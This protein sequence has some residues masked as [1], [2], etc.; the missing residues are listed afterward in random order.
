[1]EN[2]FSLSKRKRFQHCLQVSPLLEQGKGEHVKV[3][4]HSLPLNELSRQLSHT[5]QGARGST[6]ER[7]AWGR[8]QQLPSPNIHT[9]MPISPPTSNCRGGVGAL[10]RGWRSL[11]STLHRKTVV[12]FR[13][14]E[15]TR[16]WC[17][18]ASSL[19]MKSSLGSQDI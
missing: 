3:R 4:V 7:G 5:H 16:Q 2:S 12:V 19:Q 1:M 8:G 11:H 17:F 6:E 9:P 10:L 18:L 14:T 13:R 15:G